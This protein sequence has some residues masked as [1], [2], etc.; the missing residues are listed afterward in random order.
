MV[1]KAKKHLF[2][3]ILVLRRGVHVMW[4]YFKVVNIQ[5]RKWSPT[6]KWSP[7]WKWSQIGPQMIPDVDR[8]WSQVKWIHIKCLS[9][10]YDCL[11]K[12]PAPVLYCIKILDRDWISARL[13]VTKAAR[14]HVGVHYRC[15]YNW[16]PTW[17]SHQLCVLKWFLSQCFLQFSKLMKIAGRRFRSNELLERHF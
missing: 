6:A 17:F 5:C 11:W 15:P 14:D 16:I 4:I 10:Y 12:A 7:N 3:T 13:F 1:I 2:W 9:L 8:K